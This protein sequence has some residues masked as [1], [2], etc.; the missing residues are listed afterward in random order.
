MT[1]LNALLVMILI[2]PVV[3]LR[4]VIVPA[5]AP[6]YILIPAISH[7]LRHFLHSPSSLSPEN[8]TVISSSTVT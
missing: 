2:R 5:V 3:N 7:L 6:F 4:L 1:S 8:G